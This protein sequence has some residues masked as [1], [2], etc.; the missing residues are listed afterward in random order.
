MQNIVHSPGPYCRDWNLEYNIEI[1]VYTKKSDNNN[2]KFKRLQLLDEIIEIIDEL[3]CTLMDP[4]IWPS[5]SRT[6]S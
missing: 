6:T 3:S 4:N 1:G 2:K 5:R